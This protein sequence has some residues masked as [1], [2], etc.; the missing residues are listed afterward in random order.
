MERA[1]KWGLIETSPCKRIDPPKAVRKEPEFLNAEETAQF[2]TYLEDEPLQYKVIFTL[3]IFTGMRRGELLGLEWQDIDFKNAVITINRTLQ[4]VVEKG[5]YT[6]DTK[7][8]QSKRSIKLP[9]SIMGLISE[10][11][12]EQAALCQE[13][14]DAWSADWFEHPRL[15]TGWNGKPMGPN[16]PYK[17]LQSI[18]KNRGLRKVSLHSLRHTS[19]TLL[20]NQGVNIRAV[21]G[22]LGHSQTSTT[23]NIYAHQI[24]SADEAAAEALEIALSGSK[25]A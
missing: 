19:A 22:R 20:I 3:L 5:I 23:M 14:G 10:Y 16:S 8:E 15:F 17:R 21:S 6:D 7:T 12:I 24:Q 9:E 13:L 25:N 4:Y 1:V 2:L 18:L 11:K